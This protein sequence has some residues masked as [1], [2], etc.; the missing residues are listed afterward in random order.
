VARATAGSYRS[1]GGGGLGVSAVASAAAAAAQRG[2]S[3]HSA[4]PLPFGGGGFSALQEPE[5]SVNLDEWSG[6]GASSPSASEDDEK[7]LRRRHDQDHWLLLYPI[8]L[9]NVYFVS[10]YTR[11]VI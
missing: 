6:M 10:L 1:S 2:S 11:G 9:L 3:A 5:L 4:P 7:Q 8:V